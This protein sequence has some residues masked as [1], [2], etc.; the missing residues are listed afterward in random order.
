MYCNKIGNLFG[1]ACINTELSS[2]PKSERIM[3]NR[4]MIKKTFD[5]KGLKYAS[6]LSLLNTSDLIKII[7]WND[8]NGI[9][10]F[11]IS[12][13]IFPWSSEYNLEDLPDFSSIK[14][15]LENVGSLALKL[16]HRLTFHP[17]PFNKLSS[18]NDNIVSNTIKDLETHGKIFDLM[19]FEKT[20]YNKINIHIGAAYDDKKTSL[21]TFNKNLEKLSDSVRMRLT[22]EN[23]DKESLYSTLELYNGLYKVSGVPIVFDYHH[24]KFCTGGQSEEDALLL[25]LS[26]W[27]NI[28]PVTHYSESRSDEYREKCKPQAH[29]DFIYNKINNYNQKFDCMIEAKMKEQALIKYFNTHEKESL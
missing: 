8:S 27:E 5:E 6:E 29:S 24:H 17:G 13:E 20:T 3:T 18:P 15:N 7:K 14:K 1:Y 21:Y 19:G 4:S 2:V 26:T 12:S 9:K 23:D 25:A 16:G 11:R 10:F 28:K 22:V